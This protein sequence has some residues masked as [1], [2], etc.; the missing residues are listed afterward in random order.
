MS[1][2]F[3]KYGGF[4]AVSRV[5]MTFYEMVLDDDEVG[6]H[7]DNVDMPRLIDHQTKFVSS[8]MGGPAAMGDDRLEV[9][10]RQFRITAREFDVVAGLLAQAMRDNGMEEADIRSVDAAFRSKRRLIVNSASA[11]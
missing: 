4:S 1:S 2:T 5:V 6:H 9:V 7:F 11:S 10:H 8:L 3:E